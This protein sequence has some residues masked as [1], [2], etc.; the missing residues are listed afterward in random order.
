MIPMVIDAVQQQLMN[1]AITEILQGVPHMRENIRI[2]AMFEVPS[3]CVEAAAIFDLADFGSIGSND[4]IQYLLAVDRN[5]EHVQS[6]Y[7]A[8]HPALWSV[9]NDLS[10]AAL[11]AGKP[12]SL[13]GEMAAVPGVAGRLYDIGI[14]SLSVSPRFVPAVRNELAGR[15]QAK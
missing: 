10:R 3:A 11:S 14:R 8:D 15:V 2:G 7:N 6:D 12:L 5:N 4:L 1:A 9:L 13:C